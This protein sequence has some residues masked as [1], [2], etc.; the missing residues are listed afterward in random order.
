[1]ALDSCLMSDSVDCLELTLRCRRAAHEHAEAELAVR[2][3]EEALLR[4]RTNAARLARQSIEITEKLDQHLMRKLEGIRGIKVQAT[5]VPLNSAPQVGITAPALNSSLPH[6][7]IYIAPGMKPN[8]AMVPISLID[9]THST[10]RSIEDF[11]KGYSVQDLDAAFE[12]LFTVVIPAIANG[13]DA[14]YFAEIDRRTGAV[15]TR[16]LSMTYN[17]FLDNH[18]E[19]IRLERDGSGRL[20]VG[21]GQHRIWVA[22]HTGR[23]HVP[24]LILGG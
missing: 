9:V 23:S 5:S 21:N 6:D 4:F 24:A 1:M 19:A 2:I 14:N 8:Y 11:K 13:A 18:S 22:A 12:A 3:A 7:S 15:G 20:T 10:V 16:S 17:N